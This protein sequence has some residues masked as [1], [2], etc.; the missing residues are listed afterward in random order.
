MSNRCEKGKSMNER[1]KIICW[2]KRRCLKPIRGVY[3]E[4]RRHPALEE[5]FCR[6]FAETW[7]RIPLWAR[8]TIRKYWRTEP[9]LPQFFSP[10]ITVEDFKGRKETQ[11]LAICKNRG[12]WLAFWPTALRRLPAEQIRE[13][14]AHELAHVVQHANG[15]HDLGDPTT[16]RWND[17]RE[18]DA[19]EMMEAW[20]FDP[21]AI[22]R[23]W[24]ATKKRRNK[25]CRKR[26]SVGS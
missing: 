25:Q 26:R 7:V 15:W 4:R 8:R 5:E 17:L 6:L 9:R 1:D 16:H 14:I 23:A 13:L 12:H 2:L 20:G 19:D 10:V 11:A 24:V 21:D 18:V 22:D 3:L